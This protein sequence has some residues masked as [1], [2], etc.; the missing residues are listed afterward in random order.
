MRL[1]SM[2]LDQVF[3]VVDLVDAVVANVKVQAPIDIDNVREIERGR[4][5]HGDQF[6]FVLRRSINQSKQA[7]K[8]AMKA[9]VDTAILCQEPIRKAYCFIEACQS[10]DALLLD[11]M[12]LQCRSVHSNHMAERDRE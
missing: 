7:S 12:L 8:Q 6:G 1:Q 5:E 3:R 10:I 2:E 9:S 11:L 4:G